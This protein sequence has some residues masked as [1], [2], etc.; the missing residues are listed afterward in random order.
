MN[1]FTLAAM[2]FQE[3]STHNGEIKAVRTISMIEMPST[4]RT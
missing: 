3:H 2:A 4:P 1:S